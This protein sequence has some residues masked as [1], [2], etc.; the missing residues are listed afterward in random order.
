MII[1][2]EA[3]EQNVSVVAYYVVHLRCFSLLSLWLKV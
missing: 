1:H 2:M 3:I